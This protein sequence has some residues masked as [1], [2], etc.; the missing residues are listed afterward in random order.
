M[1]LTQFDHGLI[2]IEK[3]LTVVSWV[4][5]IAVTLMIVT[6]ILL[7]FFFNRPLPATWEISEVCMPAIVFMAFAYTLTLD[8]HVKM[9]LVKE[10]VSP[11][12]QM[13]F[14]MA[15]NLISFG[16]CAL[17]TYWSWLRFWTSFVINEEILAPVYV[18][19][20]PGKLM[21]PIGMAFFTL[22]YFMKFLNN[23]M[24]QDVEKNPLVGG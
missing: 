2:K 23:M 20:W 1:S 13:I 15:T 16:F 22:R 6:D 21:M 9:S 24:R 7:R 11:R 17:L 12:A 19:W 10:R 3:G 4:V 5:T 14:E 8:Q 18:P